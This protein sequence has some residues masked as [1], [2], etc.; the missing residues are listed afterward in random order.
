M[1]SEIFI[2]KENEELWNNFKKLCKSRDKSVSEQLAVYY[3]EDVKMHPVLSNQT[4]LDYAEKPLV[5]PKFK[6]CEFSNK[7]LE[8]GL[9][10]CARDKFLCLPVKCDKCKF[11]RQGSKKT[12]LNKIKEVIS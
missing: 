4:S 12:I 9:F 10:F 1:R 6:T 7:K 11:Y 3:A 5:M 8:K 2:K